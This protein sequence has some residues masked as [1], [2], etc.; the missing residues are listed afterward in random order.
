MPQK[1]YNL[2]P[3]RQQK[4]RYLFR[5]LDAN[6]SGRIDSADIQHFVDALAVGRNYAQNS[7]AYA[8]LKRAYMYI[9]DRLSVQIDLNHDGKITTDEWLTFFSTVAID[10]NFHADFIKPIERTMISLLDTDGDNRIRVVDY[11][12]LARALKLPPD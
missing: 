8:A 5:I 11:R 4:L 2:T 1:T 12:M 9:W 10:D 6:G 3:L 7:L